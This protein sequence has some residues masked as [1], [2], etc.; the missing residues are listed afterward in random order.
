MNMIS[1]VMTIVG[2]VLTGIRLFLNMVQPGR[3]KERQKNCKRVC[4]ENR[5]IFW[6]PP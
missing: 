3:K 2:T 1:T 6:C 4:E 5:Q